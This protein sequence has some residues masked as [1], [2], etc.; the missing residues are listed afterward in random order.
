MKIFPLLMLGSVT[1]LGG[2]ASTGNTS[3][4][5]ADSGTAYVA[6]GSNI[7]KKNNKPAD[8]QNVDL[9]QVENAR[10]MNSGTNNGAGSR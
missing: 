3:V 10:T 2:C 6:L 4:A 7:P 9:Q 8:S 5:S 1:L